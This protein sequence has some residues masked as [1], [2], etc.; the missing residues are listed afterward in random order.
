MR[1]PLGSAVLFLLVS[2]L[3]AQ[4]PPSPGKP[5]A[6]DPKSAA[7]WF[8]LQRGHR[9]VWQVTDLNWDDESRQPYESIV[10]G[11]VPLADGTTCSQVIEAPG[12][13][14]R[15]T[16]WRADAKGL[17]Q[18]ANADPESRG[19]D[20]KAKLWIPGPIGSVKTWECEMSR[21][22]GSSKE[23][24]LHEG[25][26]VSMSES[27]TVPAGTFSTL[28]VRF[29]SKGARRT[30]L[31]QWFA[32]G[33]GLVQSRRVVEG[34]LGHYTT[35]T[36]VRFEAGLATDLDEALGEGL[37]LQ[38]DAPRTWL[39]FGIADCHLRG[40]IAVVR[41][42]DG[43]VTCWFVGQHVRRLDR[44]N[45]DAWK[46]VF[47][48]MVDEEPKFEVDAASGPREVRIGGE[49]PLLA[50]AGVVAQVECERSGVKVTRMLAHET[51]ISEREGQLWTTATHVV[52]GRADGG[53]EVELR[54][55]LE[56]R[57]R[58]LVRVA[59]SEGK[60]GR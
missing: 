19:V 15:C 33:V 52:A 24:V 40:R 47:A 1:A 26:L 60:S 53:K 44:E 30:V 42:I 58:E 21:G 54:V 22:S 57:G 17:W 5:A 45:V 9:L 48:A 55:G 51:R 12:L 31:D 39:R 59:V 34:T 8:P 43:A 28:H 7:T 3:P 23:T 6:M 49:A 46:V 11:D 37:G 27:I 56:M 10:W 18:L 50:L 16:Y 32:Q 25:S 4:T 35:R 29:V 36:L 41:P 38:K 13:G 2:A 20:P 14:S